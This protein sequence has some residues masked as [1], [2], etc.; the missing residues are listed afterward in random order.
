[1]SIPPN[2]FIIQ[3]AP[4]YDDGPLDYGEVELAIHRLKRSKAPGPDEMQNEIF[5]EMNYEHVQYPLS[6]SSLNGGEMN[7]Y[8]RT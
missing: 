4:D 3:G 8:G 7:I 6:P 1:M 2:N 5:K